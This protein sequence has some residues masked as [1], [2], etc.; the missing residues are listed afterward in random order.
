VLVGLDCGCTF[1]RGSSLDLFGLGSPW[2]DSG[3]ESD[4]RRCLHAAYM[5]SKSTTNIATPSNSICSKVVSSWASRCLDMG[6][7][8]D[9]IL[10]YQERSSRSL[11]LL[12][13]VERSRLV[14]VQTCGAVFQTFQ[15]RYKIKM[16]IFGPHIFITVDSTDKTGLVRLM[17]TVVTVYDRQNRID[18][19]ESICGYKVSS[20]SPSQRT[21]GG[22]HSV[23]SD[24]GPQ[25]PETPRRKFSYNSASS[26]LPICELDVLVTRQW[27]QFYWLQSTILS[28]EKQ[29]SKKGPVHMHLGLMRPK[30]L[31][32]TPLV[33]LFLHDDDLI[34][35]CG[36]QSVLFNNSTTKPLG[37]LISNCIQLLTPPPER[38][39]RN[40][41]CT[42]THT[43]QKPHSMM[44]S[45]RLV[46]F[47]SFPSSCQ[48]L[49]RA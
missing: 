30:L 35:L 27:V 26:L 45:R 33:A 40:D 5:M 29:I 2:M 19:T 48:F 39:G 15:K 46:R 16:Y 44:L 12:D 3:S 43:K 1:L 18:S 28:F 4:A 32:A 21:V 31:R 9:D 49:R 7:E 13:C 17:N 6:I 20:L 34:V 41:T 36:P 23:R 10:R 38:E 11:F 25:L 8:H 24:L 42:R 37:R 22:L 47:F 14:C